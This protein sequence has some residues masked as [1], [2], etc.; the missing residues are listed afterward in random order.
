MVYLKKKFFFIL[1]ALLF[2]LQFHNM[3]S[4]PPQKGFDTQ[5]HIDYVRL[6]RREKRVPLASEGWE[7]YQPPLYY[8]LAGSAEDLKSVKLINIVTWA[9]LI[10]TGYIMMRHFFT[11]RFIVYAGTFLIGSLPV[12]LYLS[13]TISNEF[14]SAV[15]ISS[16]L[17]YYLIHFETNKVSQRKK[18]ILG[19]LLGLCFL[20]KYTVI[21]L[22]LGIILDQLWKYK[23]N[24]L[25][26]AKGMFIVFVV[27]LLISGWLYVRN[28]IYYHN[29]LILNTD[30]MNAPLDQLPGYRD[31]NFFT[32]LSG[33]L[34]LDIFH[35]HW[36]S[37][38][39][40]TYFSWYFDAH[41][42]IIPIQSYSKAGNLLIFLSL[43]L[44]I[45]SLIGFINEIRHISDRNRLII[46]YTCILIIG[47]ISFTIKIPFYSSVKA[48][49]MI[50]LV[51]PWGYFV[52]SGY[53]VWENRIKMNVV[54]TYL[55]LYMIVLMKN[56]WIL[57][58]WYIWY[59]R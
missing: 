43:P 14:F 59:R 19:I 45:L 6:M 8:F 9:I 54:Y 27:I 40:G 11:S 26:L 46:L 47:Y 58:T 10:Y 18:L 38:L 51:L 7:M 48:S 20:S 52:M 24:F 30:L 37:L 50:S 13:P 53:R 29:P 12:V 31:L 41:N 1:F 33:F 42:V 2:F 16:A 15:I 22:I 28:I 56:F 35:A 17:V 23:W 25:S 5:G 21:F 3:L 55:F 44:F 39:A 49:Y 32:D 36:Y 34:K 57:D 4:F